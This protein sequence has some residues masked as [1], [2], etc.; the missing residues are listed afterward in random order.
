MK[1]IKTKTEIV[2]LENVVRVL[3][4]ENC[5]G[6]K[7]TYSIRID[8]FNSD[9]CFIRCAQDQAKR[10]DIFEEIANILSN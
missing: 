4:I 9:S 6:A 8:Y 10:D 2:S 7:F 5:T 3:K 1:L